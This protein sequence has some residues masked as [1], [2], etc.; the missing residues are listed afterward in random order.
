MPLVETLTDTF[1]GVALDPQWSTTFGT[2]T[3]AGGFVEQEF[4]DSFSGFG[5]EPAGDYD[6]TSS[7]IY[8]RLFD[9][10]PTTG[11]D[12]RAFIEL[13]EDGA[14]APEHSIR[15]GYRDGDL[16]GEV[17]TAGPS[18]NTIFSITYNTTDHAFVRIANDGDDIDFDTSPDGETWTTRGTAS[19]SGDI[20]GDFDIS[21]LDVRLTGGDI[22]GTTT[23]S[24]RFD[25]LNIPN[26]ST[27]VDAVTVP[28]VVGD[29]TVAQDQLVDVDGVTV[30]VVVG[31]DVDVGI[32][33]AVDV[34]AVTI[35]V[36]VGQPQ[37]TFV[38]DPTPP[39]APAPTGVQLGQYEYRQLRLGAGT[40]YKVTR[41]EGLLDKPPIRSTDHERLQR[42]GRLP[43]EEF[44][45]TRTI[46]LRIMVT[47]SSIADYRDNLAGLRHALSGVGPPEPLLFRLPTV[48]DAG[49]RLVMVKSPR[50]GVPDDGPSWA[51]VLVEWPA[52]DPLIYA[53]DPTDRIAAADQTSGGAPS[54]FIFPLIFGTA[55]ETGR[56]T[57]LNS[58]NFAAPVRM[59]VTGPCIRPRIA[60]T[61]T[62]QVLEAD[63]QLGNGEILVLDS[64]TR[65]VLRGGNTNAYASLISDDWFD[66]EPGE[67]SLYFST[68]TETGSL[69]VSF[70]SAWVT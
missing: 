33:Q 46:R 48:A 47:G 34:D 68:Q 40:P 52:P 65:T 8:V 12:T 23:G 58:G 62:G 15:C 6:L 9:I 20:D 53:T 19:V 14:T 29:V 21:T 1:D 66:L 39:S 50:M 45:D 70:R 35:G 11:G 17:W 24:A 67:T 51:D 64:S 37:I 13:L 30:P 5:T 54:P 38:V 25:H 22:G 3:V 49:E 44:L 41:R 43:G 55:A 31:D 32:D 59:T 63:L 28:V 57:V 7:P 16:V 61:R 4:E 69:R 18:L 42:H 26:Q 10:V 56:V 27:D 2:V 60:N 36:A